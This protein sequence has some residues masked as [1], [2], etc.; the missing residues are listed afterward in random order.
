ML[1]VLKLGRAYS[2]Q[3][4]LISAGIE[5]SGDVVPRSMTFRQRWAAAADADHQYGHRRAENLGAASGRP[6]SSPSVAIFIV[7][8]AYA[9]SRGPP[10]TL[11]GVYVFAVIG[12]ALSSTCRQSWSRCARA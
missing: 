10:S 1:V 8:E 5:S 7:I 12:V 6:P 11:G 9:S 4:R 3:P 2:P